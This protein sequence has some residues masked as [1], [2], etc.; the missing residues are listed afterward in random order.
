M[1]R[2]SNAALREEP[3]DN[4]N[5]EGL[6][7]ELEQEN[8]ITGTVKIFN[9]DRGWGFIKGDD[10]VDYF[11]HHRCIKAKGHR[12]L[13]PGQRVKFKPAGDEKGKRADD[14]QVVG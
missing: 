3:L 6:M 9:D 4:L 7:K 2:K 1:G 13:Q 10:D 11:V 5:I 14:V 12:T 8:K